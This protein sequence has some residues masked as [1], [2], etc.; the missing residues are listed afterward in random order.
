MYPAPPPLPSAPF[1]R[2]YRWSHI[3]TLPEKWY[4]FDF[5]SENLAC[6]N[7]ACYL[8]IRFYCNCNTVSQQTEIF[9]I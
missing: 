5:L 6:K 3:D 7:V 2:L 4:G 1:R 8:Q 9:E